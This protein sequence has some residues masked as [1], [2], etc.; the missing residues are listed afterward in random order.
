MKSVISIVLVI[1]ALLSMPAFSQKIFDV[2]L[3]GA[4]DPSSQIIS[5]KNAGVYRAAISTSW[6]LQDRY[7]SMYDTLLLYGLMLPC[8]NGKVPYS[9]QACYGTGKDWPALEWVEEQIR[10]G[11]IDYFGEILNQ[12]YGIAP[13]DSSLFPYYRLAQ[14]YNLPVGIHTGGAG[15][16]HGSP[17]FNMELGNPILLKPLLTQFPRLRVWIMHSGVDHFKETIKVMKEFG[18]VYADISVISNP[19]IV[20]SSMFSIIMQAFIEAGLEDRLMFGSDNGDI[21]KVTTSVESLRFLSEQQKK[22]IYH[23]NAEKFFGG[24]QKSDF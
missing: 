10:N 7:R 5:L 15:P 17:N 3:H 6:E 8:P 1:T 22:K 4:K 2:H 23:L 14:Q 21:N 24:T 20:P 11:K 13:A 12:Y 19:D 9:L 18:E 16:G